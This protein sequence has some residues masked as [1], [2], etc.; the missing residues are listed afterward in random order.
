MLP[1]QLRPLRTQT[2][3]LRVSCGTWHRPLAADPL[4]LVGWWAGPLL[5]SKSVEGRNSE[6]RSMLWALCI[7]GLAGHIIFVSEVH[8]KCT[9]LLQGI[10]NSGQPRSVD[11]VL[12]IGLPLTKN[13]IQHVSSTTA[14]KNNHIIESTPLQVSPKT[15]RYNLEIRFYVKA[16][17]LLGS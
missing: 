10:S 3:D 8:L 1:K 6:A 4:D 14:S 7:C 16:V 11:D 9:V 15:E 13:T 2:G 5:P 17:V 12:E